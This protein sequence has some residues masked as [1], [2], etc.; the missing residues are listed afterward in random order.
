MEQARSL[1]VV[2]SGG[3]SQLPFIR[4]AN[5]LGYRAVVFDRTPLAPGAAIADMFY[6]MSTHDVKRILAE[7]SQLNK[8]QALAS[9]IS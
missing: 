5:N 8:K 3:K 9:M 2:V 1:F 4:A 6:P 7:C